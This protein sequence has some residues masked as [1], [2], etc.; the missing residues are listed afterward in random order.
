IARH[1]PGAV[2][3]HHVPLLLQIPT[4]LR[5]TPIVVLEPNLLDEWPY[6]WG[7]L[8]DDRIFGAFAVELQQIDI[9]D[10]V[11]TENVVER[12]GL[13]VVRENRRDLAAD[14]IPRAALSGD[15]HD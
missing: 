7:S 5:G 15:L 13:D 10:P 3:R 9:S 6:R 2:P 8:K 4:Q 11:N 14:S 12:N 1:N